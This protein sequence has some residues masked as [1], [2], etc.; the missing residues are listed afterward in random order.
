[1][2][3]TLKNLC[4]SL[5]F[6]SSSMSFADSGVTVLT[7]DGY[8]PFCFKNDSGNPE[9][10][11]VHLTQKI[12]ERA[13][14]KINKINMAPWARALDSGK[15][16]E[17][18]LTGLYKNPEREKIMDFVDEPFYVES[19]ILLKHSDDPFEFTGI[20]SLKGKKVGIMRGSS[21]GAE[22]DKAKEAGLFSVSETAKEE[23]N[24]QKFIKK[25]VEYAPMEK[26]IATLNIKKSGSEGKVVMDSEPPLNTGGIYMAI[27]KAANYPAASINKLKATIIE[28]KQDG[29]LQKEID[30]YLSNFKQ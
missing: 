1:M 28:M 12:F 24:F 20:D 3:K 19:I 11:Y 21:Y 7:Y 4:I 17:G 22:F 2:F 29:S 9:G 18:M 10:L 25:R 30:T 15:K 5:L 23:Q 14:L 6:V 8:A 13:N 27:G 16:G 26:S